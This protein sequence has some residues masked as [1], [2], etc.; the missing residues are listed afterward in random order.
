MILKHELSNKKLFRDVTTDLT[1]DDVEDV[2]N[3]VM[4]ETKLTLAP[5]LSKHVRGWTT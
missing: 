4:K 1:D 2:A 5:M 3:V